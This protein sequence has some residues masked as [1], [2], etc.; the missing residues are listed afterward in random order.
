MFLPGIDCHSF[1]RNA[2]SKDAG[3]VT[4][5]RQG[6]SSGKLELIVFILSDFSFRHPCHHH[7]PISSSPSSPSLSLASKLS[8]VGPFHR[9]PSFPALARALVRHH[10]RP[11][12]GS[13]GCQV[14]KSR[15]ETLTLSIVLPPSLELFPSWASSIKLIPPQPRTCPGGDAAGSVVI[16]TGTPS[17]SPSHFSTCSDP[18]LGLG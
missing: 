5:H 9:A 15:L 12:P 8:S 14:R 18:A 1:S 6:L 3:H 10:R 2:L 11:I 4:H 16:V 7:H 13:L 17:S